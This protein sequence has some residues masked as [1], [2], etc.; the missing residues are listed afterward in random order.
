MFKKEKGLLSLFFAFFSQNEK[1]FFNENEKTVY[2]YIYRFKEKCN[3]KGDFDN[4]GIVYMLIYVWATSKNY[5]FW[6][7]EK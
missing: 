1:L 3:E 6:R 2:L 5:S 4:I 7:L